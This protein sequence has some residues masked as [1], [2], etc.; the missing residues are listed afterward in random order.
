VNPQNLRRKMNS[1]EHQKIFDQVLAKGWRWRYDGDH[2]VCYPA[3]GSR[4]LILSLT[5][6]DGPATHTTRSQFKRAGLW[7]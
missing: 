5:S 1:E 6:Q 7:E 2:I 3:N 4:P